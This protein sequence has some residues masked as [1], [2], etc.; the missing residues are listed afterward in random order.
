M[1]WRRSPRD[2]GSDRLPWGDE[3]EAVALA[4]VEG[5][6]LDFVLGTL[7]AVPETERLAIFAE[8][9]EQQDYESMTFALQVDR[10]DGWTLIVEPNG[11]LSSLPENVERLSEAGRVVSVYW[12]VNSQMRFQYAINGSI[13]RSF[14]PLIPELSPEGTPLP[15]ESGLPF[16][17]EGEDPRQAAVTLAGRLTGV[18]LDPRTVLD[19]PRRTWTVP[20]SG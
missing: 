9:E 20:T 5:D 14:D 16:G 1:R 18:A 19:T 17:V 2:T 10:L 12:N 6:R 8:A 4:L 3:V 13:H 15:D 7:G 11:Y